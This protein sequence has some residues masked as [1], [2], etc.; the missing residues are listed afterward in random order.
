MSVARVAAMAVIAAMASTVGE[1][2]AVA[3]YDGARHRLKM[4]NRSN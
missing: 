1:R 2:Q 4:Q 3:H